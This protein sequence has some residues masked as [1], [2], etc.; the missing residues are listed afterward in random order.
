[1]KHRALILVVVAALACVAMPA[2]GESRW[3]S[4]D[5]QSLTEEFRYALCSHERPPNWCPEWSAW[6]SEEVGSGGALAKPE[7]K[8]VEEVKAEPTVPSKAVP[9][10]VWTPL[11]R[12]WAGRPPTQDEIELAE[13]RANEDG[14]PAAFEMLG[15]FYSAG[16]GPAIDLEKAYAK[17]ASA[18]LAGATHVKKN[19]DI[20]WPQLSTEEQAR[21]QS[22]FH[23]SSDAGE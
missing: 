16:W 11:V 21:M 22:A 10:E 15:Y 8:P 9:D 13:K 4:V 12:K 17:Y 6:I 23:A 19:L 20:L 7:K 2:A 14:D 18:F 1:M 5:W 3:D